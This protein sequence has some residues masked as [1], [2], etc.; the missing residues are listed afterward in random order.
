MT[1]T[2]FEQH[3]RGTPAV[4]PSAFDRPVVLRLPMPPLPQDAEQRLLEASEQEQRRSDELAWKLT[5]NR[6]F[7]GWALPVDHH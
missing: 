4:P 7:P 5:H 6:L 2:Y 3:L 1:V